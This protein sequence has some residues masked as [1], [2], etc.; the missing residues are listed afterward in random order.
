MCIVKVGSKAIAKTRSRL[1]Q[2]PEYCRSLMQAVSMASLLALKWL[3]LC[4]QGNGIS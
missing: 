2:L 1:L 4:Q 3:Q